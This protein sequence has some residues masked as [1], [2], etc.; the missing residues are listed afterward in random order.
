VGL[1]KLTK[2]APSMLGIEIAKLQMK[3]YITDDGSLSP[4]GAE[5]VKEATSK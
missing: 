3:G 5:A 4:K 2:V 1:S